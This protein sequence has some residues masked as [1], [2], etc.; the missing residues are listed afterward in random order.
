MGLVDFVVITGNVFYI[1]DVEISGLKYQTIKKIMLSEIQKNKLNE[2]IK[3]FGSKLLETYRVELGELSEWLT[4]DSWLELGN[5]HEIF[6]TQKYKDKIARMEL[7]EDIV[8]Y[9]KEI[10]EKSKQRTLPGFRF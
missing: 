6:P 1:L 8:K 2:S 4:Y 7:V 10:D 3:V 5:G 9:L